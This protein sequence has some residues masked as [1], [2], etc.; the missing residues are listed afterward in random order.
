MKSINRLLVLSDIVFDPI[1]KEINKSTK[2]LSLEIEYHEDLI[3]AL[4]TI[5]LKEKDNKE[6]VIIHSDQFFHRKPIDWQLSLLITI[7]GFCLKNPSLKIII[8]NCFNNS[9]KLKE[10]KYS[11]GSNFDNFQ[12]YQSELVKFQNIDNS[13]FFDFSGL[14]NKIGEENSYDYD[15]GFL[16]QMPYK[17]KLIIIFAEELSNFISQLTNEEKKVVVIDCDN[18]LWNGVVGEEGIDGVYCDKNAKGLLFYNF[19][20][21]LKNLKS[22]GFLLCLCSKNNEEDVKE[23]FRKKNMPLIWKD[24]IIKKINW[25]EKSQNIKE[26]ANLLN[27]A[28]DSLIFIDDNPFEINSVKEFTEVGKNIL[29]KNSYK[30]FLSITKDYVFRKKQVLTL[31]RNKT[32]LYE[33]EAS[34]KDLE[35][36]FENLDDFINSLNIKLDIKFN[37]ESDF[38]RIAQ[39]TEKTNQFNFNKN[40]FS[41]ND[42][43]TWVNNKNYIYSLKVTDKFGDYGTVGLILVKLK[44][45][46]AVIEN[47]LMSCRALGKKTENTFFQHV[48]D[49]LDQKNIKLESILF[50]ETNKNIPAKQFINNNKY[51]NYLRKI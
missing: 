46:N 34:R 2:N 12:T 32:K 9:F 21:F 6:I 38:E 48:L 45:K 29:F 14:I 17:K 43:L 37:D 3:V 11:M 5:D 44:N 50:K 39:M 4:K 15:L 36:S 19:Q 30:D 35:K 23:V 47:F 42:I 20:I 7:Q 8:S 41:K 28:E 24:F 27:V 25:I 33:L 49:D 10:L 22:D 13:Y 31:D 26:I 1:K 40:I 51:E 16:Y 18:T